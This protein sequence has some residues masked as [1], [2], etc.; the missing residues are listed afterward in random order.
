[1]ASRA[2]DGKL[3]AVVAWRWGEAAALLGVTN[4]EDIVA[5]LRER[6]L[7]WVSQVT[8]LD[9]A[10]NR[11][12]ATD[13]GQLWQIV[14]SPLRPVYFDVRVA[15]LDE[16]ARRKQLDGQRLDSL[17][18]GC[19]EPAVR[20]AALRHLVVVDRSAADS[21]SS[22]LASSREG[23]L[24][25]L[26]AIAH[27]K[28]PGPACTR[29]L[30]AVVADETHDHR[31]R[32][33]VALRLLEAGAIKST[34]IPMALATEVLTSRLRV[35]IEFGGLANERLGGL[36]D[37]LSARLG[38]PIVLEEDTV[39][40]D[41]AICYPTSTKSFETHLREAIARG[42]GDDPDRSEVTCIEA[43]GRRVVIRT[44]PRR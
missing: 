29:A 15:A 30:R 39:L 35:E 8:E 2:G 17:V 1:R 21:L 42:R 5:W 3:A 6:D 33:E 43:V 18:R 16:L 36:L 24:D 27:K 4:L 11:A 10:R 14:E 32:V 12:A 20:V 44:Q 7:E 23:L 13:N 26:G 9:T 31:L 38:C 25:V 28:I 37:R 19:T 34:D 22:A 40:L 41:T